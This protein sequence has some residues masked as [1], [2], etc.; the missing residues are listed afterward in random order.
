MELIPIIAA[1]WMIAFAIAL[2][3]I[4]EPEWQ[5]AIQEVRKAGLHSKFREVFV[6]EGR[7]VRTA[8]L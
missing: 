3:L 6:V 8:T 1:V 7:A 2:T 5:T 4:L